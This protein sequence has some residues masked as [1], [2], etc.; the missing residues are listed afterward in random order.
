MKN[1]KPI[2]RDETMLAKAAGQDVPTLE[3][4][5]REEFFLADVIEAIESGGGGDGLP[6]VTSDDNGDV[7]TVVEGAWAKAQPSGGVSP[8]LCTPSLSGSIFSLDKTFREI[9]EAFEAGAPIHI[10]DELDGI[11]TT[12]TII[13]LQDR[14]VRDDYGNRFVA[15]SDD[16]YPCFEV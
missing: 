10:L 13:I 1:L 16:G 12:V 15:D 8:L 3:P 6:A 4:V 7:L 2:T 9:K 11:Y 14:T 5:T